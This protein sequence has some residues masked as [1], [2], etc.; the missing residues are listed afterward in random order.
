[1]LRQP[2]NNSAINIAALL[3]AARTGDKTAWHEIV[4]RYEGHVRA[5]VATYR[6]A[7]ADAADAIQNTWLRLFE[8]ATA[9]RDPEKLGG[10][11]AT[12]ARRECLALIRRQRIERPFATIDTDQQCPEPTPDTVVIASETRRHVQLATSAL[13]D[14]PRALIDA[15]YYRPCGSYAEV[16]RQIGMPI[17]SIG[18]THIRAMRCLR[19]Q[20]HDL[21]P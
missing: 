15:L 2:G 10:W 11:L 21:R 7:P 16:A 12:T 19:S 4:R 18:P 1:M 5:S 6:P 17:G 9:I 3:E 14:R 8:H 13:S 20:L